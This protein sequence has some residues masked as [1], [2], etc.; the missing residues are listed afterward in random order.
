MENLT[1]NTPKKM[2][3]GGNWKSNGT[4]T[5]ANDFTN[6]VLNR[7]VYD[8]SKVEVVV[9]P[10]TLHLF[11]VKNQLTSDVQLAC[12]NISLTGNGA[13]TG[14]ISADMVKE[15]GVGW[16]LTG[17]SERRIKY[18]ETDK[19]VGIKTKNALDKGL[20]VMVCIGETLE[21]R[22]SG[23]TDAVNARQLAAVAEQIEDW[24]KVVIAYEPVWA[25][26]TGKTASPEIAQ[27]THANIR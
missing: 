9:A 5:F 7:L 24:S 10:T 26:G 15:F 27:E 19:D 18:G 3:V 20:S 22:E 25:I 21:E 4:L 11:P 8:T 12:Q 1:I 2:L 14:E 16:V 13:F 17:H 23:Q 6:D